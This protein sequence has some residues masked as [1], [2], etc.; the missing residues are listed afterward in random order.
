MQDL[1][2]KHVLNGEFESLKQ[3]MS[4]TD[5]MDFEEAYISSAHE[6]ESTMFYTCILDMMKQEETAE[7]HDLAFLLLVYPL[8]DVKG[9]LDSAYYHA[10]ASIKLT[11]GKEVKSLLQMLLLHAVPEPVISD[12]KAM[13]ISRQILK[14]DPSNNVARNVLKDTAKRLDNVVVDF[15]ELNNYRNAK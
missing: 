4:E 7:L 9:A 6:V 11:D 15:D 8:S 2:K 14:L 12:K 5:F 3:L 13:E 10:E 1:I